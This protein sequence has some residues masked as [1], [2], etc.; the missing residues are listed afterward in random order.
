MRLRPF[1]QSDTPELVGLLN[2]LD[3]QTYEFIPWTEEDLVAEL[4]QASSI[5]LAVDK[6]DRIVGLAYLR[7][8]W[9]SEVIGLYLLPAPEQE[10]TGNALLDTVEPGTKT[11]QLTILIDPLH[12]GLLALFET[13]AYTTESISYHMI[14]DLSQPPPAP[15]VPEGYRIRSL[16]ADEEEPLISLANNAYNLDRLQPGILAGWSAEDPIFSVDCVKVA[17]Y[18]GSL[19]SVVVGR[20]DLEYNKHYRA[21]RGYLGPAATLPYHRARGLSKALTAE[22]MELLRELGMKTA[23]LHTWQLNRPALEVT[24]ELGFRVGHEWRVLRKTIC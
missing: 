10:L 2:S 7:Q 11:G 8:R 12:Q 24:R 18:G 20:S 17:E 1:C 15:S 21:H 23:C 4:G 6:H 19:V 13:R 16:R 5:T 3:R 14:A 22:A 9:W